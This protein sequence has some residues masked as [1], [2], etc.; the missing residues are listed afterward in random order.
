MEGTKTKNFYDRV[1]SLRRKL[2]K[3]QENL[4]KLPQKRKEE[5]N[6]L[7]EVFDLGK[8][9]R[10]EKNK[11]S[12]KKTELERKVLPLSRKE[13][14]L[15]AQKKRIEERE[16]EE[17][18]PA[19][20][21]AVERER[22]DIE[23][24]RR[25]V[26]EQIWK[27]E[28]V[29]KETAK[30]LRFVEERINEEVMREKKEIEASLKNIDN[31]IENGKNEEAFLKKEII[32]AQREAKKREIESRKQK[33]EEKKKEAV[34]LKEQ[35]KKEAF[36]LSQKKEE[37]EKKEEES[38]EP[39]EFEEEQEEEKKKEEQKETDSE[40]LRRSRSKE[41]QEMKEKMDK[42]F[43]VIEENKKE[44][45]SLKDE[46]ERK[47]NEYKKKVEEA[48]SGEKEDFDQK[49]SEKSLEEDKRQIDFIREKVKEE[50]EKLAEKEKN[51]QDQGQQEQTPYKREPEE[52][53]KQSDFI[54]E[55]VREENERLQKTQPPEDEQEKAQE[56]EKESTPS[57]EKTSK[58]SH[59]EAEALFKKAQQS[60][61]AD[62]LQSAKKRFQRIK[63]EYEPQDEKSGWGPIKGK[64]LNEKVEEYLQKIEKKEKKESVVDEK[65]KTEEESSPGETSEKEKPVVREIIRERVRE[66]EKKELKKEIEEVLREKRKLEE[67]QE[68]FQKKKEEEK[69]AYLKEVKEK[70]K[71]VEREKER[72][73]EQEKQVSGEEK[74]EIRKR[75]K[76]ME[77]EMKK[78]IEEET[79]RKW[80]D[81]ISGV[82]EKVADI[83]KRYT[84]LTKKEE[85]L[86]N[87]VKE[88]GEWGPELRKKRKEKDAFE[89]RSI[90][91]RPAEEDNN[92]K[93]YEQEITDDIDEDSEE[94]QKEGKK[95]EGFLQRTVNWAKDI[96]P[97][98]DF[99]L[100]APFL[101]ALDI[102][103]FSV[104][105]FCINEKGAVVF[106]GRSILEEGIVYNGEIRDEEKLKEV[107]LQTFENAK[108]SPLQRKEG[109][110]VKGIISLP[111]SKI[112]T[113][114]FKV[115][116]KE[117]ILEKIKEEIGKNIPVPIEELYFHYHTISFSETKEKGV[118][119]VAVQKSTVEKY[120]KFLK[121]LDIDPIIFD[122][123]AGSLG[124]AL[125]EDKVKNGKK[126]KKKKKKEEEDSPQEQEETQEEREG[127]MIADIGARSTTISIFRD[128]SLLLSVSVPFGGAYFTDKIAKD[129]NISKEEAEEKKKK[130]GL[131]GKIKNILVTSLQTIVKEIKEAENYYRKEFDDGIKNIIVT[132]G[133][134]L[135]PG[136]IEHLKDELGEELELGNPLEK[137]KT[138]KDL[139]EKQGVLFVNAIGLALRATDKDP[140]DSG[141]NMLPEEI[142]KKEKR[143]QKE[144]K[145]FVRFMAVAF[146][147]FGVSVLGY[148][149]YYAFILSPER[150]EKPVERV[151]IPVEIEDDVEER[152]VAEVELKEGHIAISPDVGEEGAP[153]YGTPRREEVIGRAHIGEQYRLERK[154]GAWHLIDIDE[155]ERGWIHE[156]HIL[157]D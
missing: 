14:R 95:E 68:I 71:E 50:H 124:R 48:K 117:N 33:E 58:I 149:L 27:I 112:F 41:D 73:K 19:K 2:R 98:K 80:E 82:E 97:S 103:D 125:L 46:L 114:Q 25:K 111:D 144:R 115:G 76:E 153:V 1:D 42:L 24:K 143:H 141:F 69:N 92:K 127:E 89:Y 126:T 119:C 49:T 85:Q 75:M 67:E 16:R 13:G 156:E 145:R 12:K 129:L 100:K 157:V 32:R 121:L 60:F 104:E 134:A 84:D 43:N 91:K 28:D 106:F 38:R 8:E 87:K 34:L 22:W 70:E 107:L 88:I 93:L 4:K 137:I 10:E 86:R 18:N 154:M 152:P 146:A 90:Y 62:S 17:T 65:E 47:E 64:P 45:S 78:L 94:E 52:D 116:E 96:K 132:G 130:L 29:I 147:I 139:D 40:I 56:P 15:R 66:P 151:E 11:A 136:M 102:S 44:I 59:S 3:T 83:N 101:V 138:V 128:K 108:P 72:L 5:E 20:R 113:Q 61:Y 21:R 7:K 122:I 105:V 99:F 9:L 37:E 131:H 150:E 142:K 39:E 133:E 30:D 81:R 6:R 54:R 74:E 118:L 135:L 77:E 55:Q 79:S 36:Q 23:E 35:E 110:R 57:S 123:E 53:K 140:I 120:A 155:E 63:D 26:E 148:S 109:T 31:F 51:L